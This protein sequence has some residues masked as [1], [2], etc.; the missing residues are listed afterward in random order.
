M[1][2][3]DA[4]KLKPTG[5]SHRD[6]LVRERLRLHTTEPD[7]GSRG[8]LERQILRALIEADVHGGEQ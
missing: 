7:N 2:N 5:D 1:E 8:W 3:D 4:W 6:K